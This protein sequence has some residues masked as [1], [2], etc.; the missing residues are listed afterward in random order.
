[1]TTTNV[2]LFQ[3]YH[4]DPLDRLARRSGSF[5]HQAPGF[6]GE[7]RDPLTGHYLLG[8]GYRAFNTV[9]M[10][11]NSPDSFSPLGEGGLNAYAY[12][13]GDP[14]NQVDPSGH[15]FKRLFKAVFGKSTKIYPAGGHMLEVDPGLYLFNTQFEGKTT[16]FIF[17]HGSSDFVYSHKNAYTPNDIAH[18]LNNQPDKAYI[19]T[20]YLATCYSASGPSPFAKKLSARLQKPVIGNDGILGATPIDTSP[21][22]S[23][24]YGVKRFNKNLVKTKT[25]LVLDTHPGILKNLIYG[26]TYR[27][28]TFAEYRRRTIA[29]ATQQHVNTIRR[30]SMP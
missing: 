9:L 6:N 13:T 2:T 29:L 11:F 26:I 19:D 20:Y 15:L 1:M 17:G 14:V 27:P 22:R 4:Y 5:P 28:K 24:L 25:S 23:W 18:I 8:N 10:R 21:P 30:P 12:C 16:T 7:C 3:R